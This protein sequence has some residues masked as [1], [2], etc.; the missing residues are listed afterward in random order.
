M[1][2]TETCN[3]GDLLATE[4]HIY[5]DATPTLD[6]VMQTFEEH[7]RTHFT[8]IDGKLTPTSE[9]ELYVHY[10]RRR[11]ICGKSDGG[12]EAYFCYRSPNNK[13]VTQKER[14]ARLNPLMAFVVVGSRPDVQQR[15][16]AT[17]PEGVAPG[18]AVPEQAATQTDT[19]AVVAPEG[20]GAP[21]LAEQD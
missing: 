12:W 5:F 8:V 15:E 18:V 14:D 11:V 7:Q 19:A 10:V 17:A 3:I 9:C 4:D 16:T 13:V 20:G 6:K 21:T 2:T 1:D